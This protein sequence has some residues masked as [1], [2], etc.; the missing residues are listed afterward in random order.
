[1]LRDILTNKG[2]PACLLFFSLMVGGSLFYRWYVN[3]AIQDA[4]AKHQQF[5]QQLE[6]KRGTRTA[7]D[8]GVPTDIEVPGQAEPMSVETNDTPEEVAGTDTPPMESEAH[9]DSVDG[10]ESDA[11]AD[12]DSADIQVSPYGFGPYPELP[13]GWPADQIWPCISANHELMTRVQ[14]KLAHQGI[15]T[16]GS[17]MEDG[18]VYPTY[19]GSVYIK[20]AYREKNGTLYI[21]DLSGDSDAVDR[22]SAIEE[23]RGDGFTKADIPLDIKMLSYEEAGIDPYT[24]L[25]LGDK[26]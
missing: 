20:W 26:R 19:P 21:T 18:L 15:L 4:D 13:E 5:L 9:T 8:V 6:T 17:I 24:F 12:E 10:F 23:A 7:Q 11:I 22:I 25:D 2:V 16:R 14:V 1:M 3:R